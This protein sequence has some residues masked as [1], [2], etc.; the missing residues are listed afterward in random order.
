[1]YFQ[2]L[3]PD[4]PFGL[5]LPKVTR[6]L[7]LQN[8]DAFFATGAIQLAPMDR[9]RQ[10]PDE[11]CRDE[12]EG[13]PMV[14]IIHRQ[15][16]PTLMAY[17]GF[18][19][20]PYVLCGSMIEDELTAKRFGKAAGIHIIQPVGFFAALSHKIPRVQGGLMGPCNYSLERA[21]AADP[22][23]FLRLRET[24]TEEEWAREYERAMA[25][26]NATAQDALFRKGSAYSADAE[27][28]FI[29]FSGQLSNDYL[30]VECPDAVQFCRR[31][32]LPSYEQR[33]EESDELSTP[34]AAL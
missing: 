10:H 15:L 13:R 32:P 21:T 1:M 12:A 11:I 8:V 20:T 14:E 7:S 19:G 4:K 16:P 9:F 30:V 25:S 17:H 3:E 22:A 33:R 31:F 23:P 29:W 5:R 28:R 6:Y 34:P 26:A 27:F 2:K 24:Y 18:E